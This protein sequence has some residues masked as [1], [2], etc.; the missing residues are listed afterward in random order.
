MKITVNAANSLD[1]CS[2]I[3]TLVG[4]VLDQYVPILL[5]IVI[6]IILAS[7]LLTVSYFLGPRRYGSWRKLI[8][9]E[10]G[11]IPKGDT[12]EKV[13]LKYYLVGA[14]F[15]LFDIEIVFLVAWAVVFRE[16]GMVALVEVLAFLV[17]IMGGYF[18]VLKKGALKW[19]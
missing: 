8:P 5:I 6:A 13:S 4:V 11:M 10:S 16:F 15:I 1:I 19:E 9:Y 17:I 3:I 7:V 2:L 12:R 18:Y 14:L